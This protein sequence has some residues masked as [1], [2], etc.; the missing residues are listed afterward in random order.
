MSRKWILY[1]EDNEDDVVLVRDLLPRSNFPVSWATCGAKARD[2]LKST[3]YDLMLLDHGLP[4]TNS[5]LF[6]EEVRNCYPKMPVIIL[7]GREDEALAVSAM[8][9]GAAHYVIKDT[10]RAELL[11][12]IRST[13]DMHEIK[14]LREEAVLRRSER[15]YQTL[16]SVMTEGVLLIDTTGMVI[17]ANDAVGRMVEAPA[18]TLTGR[19]A[20]DLFDAPSSVYFADWFRPFLSETQPDVTPWEARLRRRGSA[21]RSDLI[22]VLMSGRP[23]T[24]ELGRHEACIVTL[25]DISELVQTRRRLQQRLAEMERFQRFFLDRE[26]TIVELKARIRDYERRLGI[27]RPALSEDTL[28]KLQERLESRSAEA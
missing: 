5:L 20:A 1:V 26:S 28:R 19:P 12:L 2:R 11:P 9:K 17:Y 7:S 13:L 10:M 23:V 25:S 14:E 24:D 27:E 22:S 8:A 16:L 18:T 21:E 6:L 3:T 4:D 15:L